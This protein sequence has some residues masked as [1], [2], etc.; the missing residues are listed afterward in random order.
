ML[1]SDIAPAKVN[2]ALHVLGQNAAGYH[3]LD[4]LVMFAHDVYD[5][6]TYDPSKAGFSVSGPKA[7][8]VPTGAENLCC[9]ARA[10][11]GVEG[12]LHL[13]KCLPS[14]AGIG[15]GSADAAAVLR[16]CQEGALDLQ[17]VLGLGADVPM[18]VASQTARVRGIGDIIE[19]LR[20]MGTLFAV[21]VNPGA[22]VS[23]PLVFA[24]LAMKS[25]PPLTPAPP[26]EAHDLIAW[27]AEQRND[28]EPPAIELAPEIAHCLDAIAQSPDVR[29]ARMSGSGSTCFG[30][31]SDW[32]AAQ[33]AA[34]F[35]QNSLPAAWVQPTRLGSAE[36]GPMR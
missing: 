9:R 8:N 3:L 13:E 32:P 24:K 7:A 11:C 26:Q 27:L 22:A 25:N 30:L 15:G 5:R 4:S 14:Q 28:L 29:L 10:V 6:L 23:T 34:E 2:L 12:H 36:V 16:L 19:P 1:R 31:Y 33:S 20:G 35:L 17:V 21:L 18:C